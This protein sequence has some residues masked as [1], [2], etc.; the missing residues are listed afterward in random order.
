V[1]VVGVGLAAAASAVEMMSASWS[2]KVRVLAMVRGGRK[3]KLNL[4]FDL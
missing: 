4:H 2:C 3:E 1:H